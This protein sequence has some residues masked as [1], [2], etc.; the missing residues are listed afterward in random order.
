MMDFWKWIAGVLVV[1]LTSA[2]IGGFLA[3]IQRSQVELRD[4]QESGP[5]Q[6]QFQIQRQ[7]WR[8]VA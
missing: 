7:A 4:L 8:T 2:D 3:A 5:F 1:E 6:I